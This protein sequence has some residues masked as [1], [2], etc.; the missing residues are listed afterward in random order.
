MEPKVTVI[1][2]FT[3]CRYL[4]EVYDEMSKQMEWEEG[5]GH[6]LDALWDILWGMPY[7][8]NDFIIRRPVRFTKIPYGQNEEF[9]DYVNRICEVFDMA[10]NHGYLTY[11]IE[12][13]TDEDAE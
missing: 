7:K 10:Q 3:K 5:Y 9:T 12:Y 13:V 4:Q 11:R 2:D 1:L 8:G 6:N